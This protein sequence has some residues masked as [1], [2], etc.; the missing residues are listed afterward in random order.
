MEPAPTV[1]NVDPE[2]LANATS[3]AEQQNQADDE[4]Q[5]D[6]EDADGEVGM[7]HLACGEAGMGVSA[8]KKSRDRVVSVFVSVI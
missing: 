2:P 6:T 7:Q 8:S 3:A 1:D 4:S 5:R